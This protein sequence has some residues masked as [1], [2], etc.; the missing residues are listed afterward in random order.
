M[1]PSGGKCSYNPIFPGCYTSEEV[2]GGSPFLVSLLKLD[3]CPEVGMG[4]LQTFS[5]AGWQMKSSFEVPIRA[6]DWTEECPVQL[7]STVFLRGWTE[8]RT[9]QEK[10][11]RS[12]SPQ[13]ASP[14]TDA[15]LPAPHPG[16]SISDI[17]ADK[18]YYGG[19]HTGDCGERCPAF[20]ARRAVLRCELAEVTEIRKGRGRW[21]SREGAPGPLSTVPSGLT[22]RDTRRVTERLLSGTREQFCSLPLEDL[23]LDSGGRVRASCLRSWHPGSSRPSSATPQPSAFPSAAAPPVP[24]AS[25]PPRPSPYSCPTRRPRRPGA[26]GPPARPSSLQLFISWVLTRTERSGNGSLAGLLARSPHACS[27]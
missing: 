6:E 14:E 7:A 18:A 11:P 10:K 12:P 27:S 3:R 20:L 22:S 2:T 26:R 21:A 5:E 23:V 15:H 25:L 19:D 9:Q 1:V 16:P 24:A 4:A 13:T 17:T 8:A